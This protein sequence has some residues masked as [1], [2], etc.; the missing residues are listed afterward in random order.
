MKRYKLLL[1]G[2]VLPVFLSSCDGWLDVRPEDEIAEEDVFTS[3][4][5]FRHA[6]NGIYYSMESQNM[7]GMHLSWGVVDAL[8]QVYDYSYAA[9]DV[10]EYGAATYAWDNSRLKP[11]ISS[12]WKETYNVVAN[13]NNL[14]QQIKDADSDMFYLKNREKSAIWG[15]ALALRAF[16]Q[17]D[18]L[19]LFA[20]APVTSPGGRKFIPYVDVYPTYVSQLK[21]VEECLTAIIGDLKEAK[22]L[23]WEVDSANSFAQG[24]FDI[25][26]IGENTF[27]NRRG[28]R[29][30]YWAATALLARVYLY[31][32]QENAALEQANEVIKFAK[33]KSAFRFR[34][35]TYNGDMKFT[36]DVIWGLHVIDLSKL[37]GGMTR[38]E[39]N[40]PIYLSICE[41]ENNYFGEDLSAR[42]DVMTSNDKRF[43]YWIEDMNNYHYY[44]RFK[45]YDDSKSGSYMD[46]ANT[47][48][49]MVR[50]SEM[51][52]IAAEVLAKQGT[53]EGLT[54]AKT[55]LKF[56][57]QGRGLRT[58]DN[59]VLAVDNALSTD[60]FMDVLINDMRRDW[61]GEGQTFYIYKR[62]NKNI[63]ADRYKSSILAS[64]KIFVVPL[65]D[66]E[67]N[68]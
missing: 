68:L 35:N 20:P 6:L 25:P 27:L 19:R 39:G 51:Y 3:G 65:P 13:C 43:T 60:A 41:A 10:M 67:T 53:E 55:H 42:N 54:E 45:K 52:Y 40:S 59:S 61:M 46:I 48:V 22:K 47:M 33:E 62:L 18:M 9:A 14:I 64:E 17:F 66:G 32:Q 11:V 23:L 12:M 37:Y 38:L 49:P 56:V 8:G 26:G 16:L 50:M 4:N 63:P 15:E 21:T 28:Y 36:S 57:K 2:F 5:G 30:N 29:L 34:D 7:Y 44:Y 1:L 24:V 58:S 31:A